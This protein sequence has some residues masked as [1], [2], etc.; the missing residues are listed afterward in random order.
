M[1]HCRTTWTRQGLPW[2]LA[3]LALMVCVACGATER[4]RLPVDAWRAPETFAPLAFVAQSDRLQVARFSDAIHVQ[5]GPDV[6]AYYRI[7]GNEYWLWVQVREEGMTPDRVAQLQD[8]G[9]AR[10]FD[11]WDRAMVVYRQT[12]PTVV[13]APAIYVAPPSGL[14]LELNLR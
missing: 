10:A 7:E 4:Y 3:G 1:L 13:P 14:R 8:W 5:L 11:I 9:K 2:L 12:M 6:W